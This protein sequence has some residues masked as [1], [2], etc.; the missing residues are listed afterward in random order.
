MG[1]RTFFI[2][3]RIYFSERYTI[4]LNARVPQD[5]FSFRGF[6][7]AT[8][9]QLKIRRQNTNQKRQKWY[10]TFMVIES[11]S[12]NLSAKEPGGNFK[13]VLGKGGGFSPWERA[14]ATR[15]LHSPAYMEGIFEVWLK[16]LLALAR[17][18]VSMRMRVSSVGRPANNWRAENAASARRAPEMSRSWLERCLL[19][20]TGRCEWEQ[21][22]PSFAPPK[23]LRSNKFAYS[24]GFELYEFAFGSRQCVF[25]KG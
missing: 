11:L 5:Q 15:A 22:T 8:T 2:L 14:Q 4:K 23:V 20:L 9:C 16:V 6:L 24:L 17:H 3:G 10:L 13:W 7:W 19:I 1:A 12:S 25:S 18:S 21:K